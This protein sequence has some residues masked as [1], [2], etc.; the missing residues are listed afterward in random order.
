[1]S[2]R[3]TRNTV[4]A[5]GNTWHIGTHFAL[6]LATFF[7]F[8]WITKQS[9]SVTISGALCYMYCTIDIV[10]CFLYLS[11]DYPSNWRYYIIYCC[12]SAFSSACPP[13]CPSL[14]LSS[15]HTHIYTP[16]TP[17]SSLIRCT[18][19]LTLQRRNADRCIWRPSPYRAVNTFHLGY[20]NQSVYA[21]SGKS[22]C[23]FSDKYKTHKYSV[24]REYSCWMLNCWCIT[25]PVGFKDEVQTALFKDPVRTAL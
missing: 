15:G 4:G 19:S 14:H 2:T 25:W 18:R 17:T 1:M 6:S 3:S 12:L 8:Q 5:A 24:G 16:H 10:L 21:V 9:V 11:C 13:C 7:D 20:K 22:R 23:F